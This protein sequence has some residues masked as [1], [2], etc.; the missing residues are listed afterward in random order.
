M[1]I[2]RDR[3]A[4]SLQPYR[5]TPLSL[6][7]HCDNLECILNKTSMAKLPRRREA[8]ARR[9]SKPSGIT[10]VKTADSPSSGLIPVV[11]IG[12]SAGGIEALGRF[13]DAMP[14]DSGCAFLVVLHL[15]PRHESEMA[16]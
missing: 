16:S 15:D 4:S 2:C 14:P 6:R 1:S 9:D 10:E 7:T 12:A 11:G 5:I 8:L 3:A 13:F